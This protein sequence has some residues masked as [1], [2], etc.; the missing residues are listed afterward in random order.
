MYLYLTQNQIKPDITDSS[1]PFTSSKQNI[2]TRVHKYKSTRVQEYKSSENIERK[3]IQKIQNLQKIQ[4]LTKNT[5]NTKNKGQ[6]KSRPLLGQKNTD[7]LEPT[8]NHATS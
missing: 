7:T 3:N 1:H 2:K 8:K 5:L 4:K 6:Q